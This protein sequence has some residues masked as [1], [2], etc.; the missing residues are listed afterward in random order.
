LWV[1]APAI[2][3]YLLGIHTFGDAK[4]FRRLGTFN[5]QYNEEFQNYKQELYYS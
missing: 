2:F 3:G 5:R 4:E 1:A